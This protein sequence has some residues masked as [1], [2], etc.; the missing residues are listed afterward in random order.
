LQLNRFFLVVVKE[1]RHVV[2][3]RRVLL[4]SLLMPAFVMMLVGY[5]F[6]GDIKHVPLAIVDE[7]GTPSSRALADLLRSTDTFR[8][9]YTAVDRNQA[10]AFVRS[11]KVKAA[12]II[13]DGFEKDIK[14]G[15]ATVYL[16][17]DG[18][19]PVIAG[20]AGPALEAMAQEF[21]AGIRVNISPIIL[22]NPSLR[23]VD[24][25]APSI[26]GLIIQFLP[27]FLMSISLAGEKERGTIEQLVV[28]PIS[29]S[30]IL[31]G[32]MV[33]YVVIG[34]VEAGLALGIAMGLFGVVM[35]GSILLVALFLL[36]FT[37]ASVSVG[38][39]SSVFAKN[40]VQAIQQI[41]PIIYVSIFM[42]GVFYPLESMPSF[43]QPVSYMIPLTYMNHALRGLVTKGTGLEVVLPDFIA[44]GIYTCAVMALAILMFK[45]KLE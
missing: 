40:Q 27:T 38:T 29:G 8:V 43:L 36:V 20:M 12:M 11:G 41:I 44:L 30:E 35:R 14:M 37:V 28:T 21:H 19:D 18:S 6:S 17:L 2:R 9:A 33:A 3:N 26:V 7:D 34:V 4:I 1:F 22:F 31:F 42:S 13:P 16:I 45:K 5:A 10:E 15:R 39:L 32:K 25:L 24:F 23:Y